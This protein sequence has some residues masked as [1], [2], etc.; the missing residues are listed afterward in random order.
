[1]KKLF[2]L[3]VLILTSVTLSAQPIKFGTSNSYFK[4]YEAPYA[5]SP[6]KSVVKRA[7]PKNYATQPVKL[8]QPVVQKTDTMIVNNYNYY[9]FLDTTK[10][11]VVEVMKPV[12]D[13]NFLKYIA[14]SNVSDRYRTSGMTK[15]LSGIG[16]QVIGV[17]LI[18]YGNTDTH[19]TSNV[20]EI[21]TIEYQYPVYELVPVTPDPT[22]QTQNARANTRVSL[23][24]EMF[25]KSAPVT[26]TYAMSRPTKSVSSSVI[27]ARSS[28]I[29][30]EYCKPPK[31]H[32]NGHGGNGGNGGN[33]GDGGTGTGGSNT[34]TTT[35]TNTTYNGDVTNTT[36]N[37]TNNYTQP[38]TINNTTNNTT[39]NYNG[40][41][42]VY[43]GDVTIVTPPVTELVMH[44]ETGTATYTDTHQVTETK[45]RNK[46]P[47]YVT[48]GILAAA[49]VALEV[50]GII[51][52]HKANVYITQNSIGFTY[53]F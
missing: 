41:T 36:N 6:A 7:K 47:Y 22:V 26:P 4:W 20:T 33:G 17:G 34:T 12:V 30:V 44:L 21:H 27:T 53:K 43:N 52:F 40:E 42:T 24:N 38:V 50:L 45:E 29:P 23:T 10:P 25:S 51:D 19:T 11:K 37:T 46:T 1:M 31:P 28:N 5:I 13:S 16:A 2:I 15:I 3:F 39:N 8:T 49:G 48:G 9:T 35:T 14:M 18:L 32:G